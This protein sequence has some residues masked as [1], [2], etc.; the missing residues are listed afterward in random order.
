[1]DVFTAD[2]HQVHTS[3]ERSQL[4]AFLDT[5]RRLL[6]ESLEGLSEEEARRQLVPSRTTLLGLVK[7]ATYVEQI[8]F[9]EA[10]TG[11]PRAELGLPATPDES[12]VL[13]DDDTISTTRDAHR[14]ACV[15]AV[16]AVVPLSLDDI[17]TGHWLGPLSLR[18][19]YLHCI[20]E[21]AQHLGHAEILRE[22][23]LASR[24]QA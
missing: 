1:M 16:A 15:A 8:W 9:N 3:D 2:P 21:F 12:F 6:N 7:H 11:T 14:Q 19:I 20:R 10:I 24:S 23:I 5:Y 4:E 17:V 18:W 13:T 22:Q